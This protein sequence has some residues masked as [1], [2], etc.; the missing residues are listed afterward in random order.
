MATPQQIIAKAA[1]Q[2]GVHE[3]PDGSNDGPGVRVFQAVTGAF[4]APW[5]ASFVQWVLRGCGVGPIANDS[6]GAYYIGDWARSHGL[7]IAKPEPG[8]VAVYHEGQGHIG[9]VQEIVP[10]GFYAIE[11][12]YSNSVSRVRRDL[13]NIYCLF[14]V[15]GVTPKPRTVWLPR[16]EIVGS[17]SGHA[18]VFVK[19]GKWSKVGPQIP[20]LVAKFRDVR[21]RRKLVK[22]TV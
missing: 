16:F 13:T 7:T 4:R 20:S 10:G 14:R 5:C 21:V 18:V 3:V 19:L 9:I 12:N 15:P 2:V 8:C 22:A 6:A 1:S 17:R 11:G